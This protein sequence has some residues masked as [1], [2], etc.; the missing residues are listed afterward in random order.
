MSTPYHW[1]DLLGD[2]EDIV[3]QEPKGPTDESLQGYFCPN[4]EIMSILAVDEESGAA[5]A[6]LNGTAPQLFNKTIK[7][8]EEQTFHDGLM[9]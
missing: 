6:L 8:D 2:K 7:L 3:D 4:G 1:T 5:R 9:R